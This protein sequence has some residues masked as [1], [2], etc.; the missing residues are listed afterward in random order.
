MY[1]HTA[2]DKPADA[3][4]DVVDAKT[5]PNSSG[6]FA[7]FLDGVGDLLFSIFGFHLDFYVL[8]LVLGCMFCCS[9]RQGQATGWERA[10]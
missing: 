2:A 7:D 10:L 1:S 9:R 5:A 6:F 4:E 3:G 8:F